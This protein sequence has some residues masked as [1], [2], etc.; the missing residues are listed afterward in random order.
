MFL[1]RSRRILA[2]IE[3]AQTELSQVHLSPRGRLRVSLPQVGEPFLSVLAQFKQTY[4]DVDLD[5][6]FT[7][8]RVDVIEEGFDAVIRSG[9][10]PDSRLTARRLGSYRMLLAG[11]P[12]YFARRGIPESCADLAGHDCIQFRYP[13]TG[14]LQVWPLCADEIAADFQLPTSVVCNNLE[15]RM[16]FAL[17]GL[18]IAYLPDFAIGPHLAA[19]RLVHVLPRCAEHPA[20]FHIMWPSG[21]H[22]APKFRVLIDF[23]HAH[24]FPSTS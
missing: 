22:L 19:G 23:L 16:L 18:G 4:A 9:D 5:L 12:E 14:K 11:S 8:R 15:A 24:L 10:V 2:E 17:Q 7:D 13:N 21:K 3:A 6:D 20:P 1:E